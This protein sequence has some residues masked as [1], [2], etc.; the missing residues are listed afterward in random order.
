VSFVEELESVLPPDLPNRERVIAGS[1]RHLEMI[2]EINPVMNLTR[3][4]S[5][6][7]A[8]IKHVLDSV[9]PWRLFS[10]ARTVMDA[11]TGPGFPGIPL[12]LIFPETQFTLVE[13][14]GK[15][16]RFVESVVA[17][18]G[19]K[20]VRVVSERVEDLSKREAFDVVTARAFAPMPKAL[21]FLAPALKR[22]AKAILYKGPDDD[23]GQHRV[24]M[25][26]ELPEG[27]GNR[28]MVEIQ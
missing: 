15:K 2:A 1:A 10:G 13:S 4:V 27:M 28:I 12:A 7:E 24:S 6:R 26:Y 3:I 21:K 25:R 20:N 19:L 16:A 23:N 17:A 18:L 9:L 5:P 22:G 8:A 11:G 14:T